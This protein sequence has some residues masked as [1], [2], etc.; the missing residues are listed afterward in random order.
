MRR[1]PDF[2]CHRTLTVFGLGIAFLFLA[3]T[4]ETSSSP[5]GAGSSG[6]SGGSSPAITTAECT[7]RCKGKLDQCGAPAAQTEQG[8]AQLC[9]GSIT[10]AQAACFEASDCEEIARAETVDELCPKNTGSSGTSSGSSGPGTSSGS[11]G[12]GGPLPQVTI[13]GSF[14]NVKANHTSSNGKIASVISIAP[15]P[16]FSPS[17]PS[18]LP[19]IN[20]KGVTVTVTSPDLGDCKP[21][22]NLTLNPSQVGVVITGVDTLPAADCATFTDAVAKNGFEATVT[23]APY[24]NNSVKATVKIDL[25]P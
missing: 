7:D 22:I 21:Q 20:D 14:G 17:M 15:E 3:C 12:G 2:I 10:Q 13:T 11:S 24:P 9:G 18:P 16:K 6:T 25:S 23:N 19:L 5:D 4:S 1:T 8:C